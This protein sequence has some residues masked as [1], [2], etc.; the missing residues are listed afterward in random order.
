[1][2]TIVRKLFTDTISR[3]TRTTALI[4]I[5]REWNVVPL[6]GNFGGR[7]GYYRFLQSP[8]IPRMLPSFFIIFI[9]IIIIIKGEC[10]NTTPLNSLNFLKQGWVWGN[11]PYEKL[12]NH[13]DKSEKRDFGLTKSIFW[14][15]IQSQQLILID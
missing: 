11:S 2:Y 4:Y 14:K 1:M 6:I 13:L 5:Y 12:W 15:N 8:P 9:I 10:G 7:V 3:K